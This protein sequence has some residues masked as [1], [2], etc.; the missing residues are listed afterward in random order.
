MKLFT[1]YISKPK[2][3]TRGCRI[4]SW[5]KKTLEIKAN[6]IGEAHEQVSNTWKEWNINMFWPKSKIINP[7]W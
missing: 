6:N 3:S 5:Y 4:T 2:W 1:F 7:R